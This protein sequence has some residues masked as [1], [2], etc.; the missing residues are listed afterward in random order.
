MEGL[1]DHRHTEERCL[2]S[3][4]CSGASAPLLADLAL[5]AG[6]QCPLAR[7]SW[8][9]YVQ[10]FPHTSQTVAF[11][12]RLMACPASNE[13]DACARVAHLERLVRPPDLLHVLRQMSPADAVPRPRDIVQLEAGILPR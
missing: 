2:P 12:L 10:A 7:E 4:P 9:R 5:R 1:Y 8:Q 3:P 11:H 6:G 13:A